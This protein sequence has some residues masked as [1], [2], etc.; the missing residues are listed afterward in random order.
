MV[1]ITYIEQGGKEWA[2]DLEPGTSLMQGAVDNSVLGIIGDCGGNCSCATCHVYVDSAWVDR[3][4]A[5]EV[6]EEQLLE[7]V[8]EAR[9]NSRLSC[10]I[11]AIEELD[12]LVVHL[13]Q[14]QV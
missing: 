10:Q 8:Y 9:P 4:G 6:Q 14:R 12:G 13:P 1:K 11:T 2:L 7:E 3:V 5:K